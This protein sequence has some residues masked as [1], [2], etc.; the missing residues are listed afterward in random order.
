MIMLAPCAFSELV[1]Q[2]HRRDVVTFQSGINVIG[3]KAAALVTQY[4]FCSSTRLHHHDIM[5]TVIVPPQ[6]SMR[7]ECGVHTS[8][9]EN[10]IVILFKIGR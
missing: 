1:V 10:A 6:F 3:R 8:A 5:T 9:V 4:D 7:L 2:P